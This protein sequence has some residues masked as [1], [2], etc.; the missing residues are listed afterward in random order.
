MGMR[1]TLS[2]SMTAV[3]AAMPSK[4]TRATPAGAFGGGARW[5]KLQRGLQLSSDETGSHSTLGCARRW[6]KRAD[7]LARKRAAP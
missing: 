3:D 1:A 7:N 6:A 5:T 2:P 4:T